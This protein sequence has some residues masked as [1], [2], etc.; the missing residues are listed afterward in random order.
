[1]RAL[2][3]GLQHEA[4]LGPDHA[5]LVADGQA[6]EQRREAQDG[7]QAHIELIALSGPGR[8]SRGHRV[9]SLVEHVIGIHADGHVL[10]GLEVS[11]LAI[12]PDPEACQVR[13]LIVLAPDERGVVLLIVGGDDARVAE[14]FRHARQCTRLAVPERAAEVPAA[15]LASLP[16]GGQ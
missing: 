13:H 15:P 14:V 6:P 7:H 9:G 11:S 10:A 16:R 12:R 3:V 2:I 1:M 8:W 5:H 4:A